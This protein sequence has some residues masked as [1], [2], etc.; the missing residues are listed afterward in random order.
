MPD[1]AGA[2]AAASKP[3]GTTLPGDLAVD[4]YSLVGTALNLRGV[5]YRDGGTDPKGFDCSGFT[6]FVFARHGIALPRSVLDQFSA[7]ISVD[8]EDLEPGDLLFF[9]TTAPGA[10]HVAIAVGGDEFI[11]AP[12]TTGVVR[13]ERLGSSYWSRRFLGARRVL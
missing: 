12:S 2:P 7:G 5:P 4:G 3:G 13:V 11:H 8:A 10:T 9:T 1:R 6:Q